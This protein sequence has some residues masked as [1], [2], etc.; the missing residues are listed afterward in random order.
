[1]SSE[2]P[3]LPPPSEPPPPGMPPPPGYGAVPPPPVGGARSGELLE[4]F[5]A[6]LIDGVLLAVV[7]GVVIGAI[8][9]GLVLGESG[10]FYGTGS[11]YVAAA[12][13][14][15]LSAALYLGY[16]AFLESSRGQTVGKMVLKLRTVDEHGGPVT[17]EQA[18]RRNAWSAIGVLGVV[19]FLGFLGGLAGLVAVVMI[20]VT[21][22]QDPVAR[23]GWHDRF[24]GGTRVVKAD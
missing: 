1:M 2:M 8:V 14:S 20:A 11:S 6:R 16:F 3:P 15:V 4:R 5:A 10:G 19:P 17:L 18:V 24:A 21:I 13:S 7:N 23:R 9:V 22:N 12:V